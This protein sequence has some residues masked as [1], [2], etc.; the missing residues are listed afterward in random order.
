MINTIIITIIATIIN[1]HH[2]LLLFRTARG[3]S[4]LALAALL[5]GAAGALRGLIA[6]HTCVDCNNLACNHL[7]HACSCNCLQ[8][9]AIWASRPRA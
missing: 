5:A 2:L 6:H 3:G 7:L 8:H 1:Y 9:V 4:A